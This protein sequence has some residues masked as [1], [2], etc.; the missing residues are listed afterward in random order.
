MILLKLGQVFGLVGLLTVLLVR[1]S[2]L[3]LIRRIFCDKQIA[4]VGRKIANILITLSIV[5]WIITEC[6]WIFR[7][8]PA[9]ITFNV[10]KSVYAKCLD[11]H[12]MGYV[13]GGVSL[14]LDIAI[15]ALPSYYV[16]KL[17]IPRQ[18]RLRI[19]SV[20]LIGTFACI[21]GALRFMYISRFVYIDATCKSTHH[22]RNV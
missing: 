17:Q 13:T 19:G 3:I 4:P 6:L 16:P 20:F 2:V 8:T 10:A 14:A 5:H 15:L 1:I 7:C 9:G 22:P 21:C 11:A 18:D 12:I